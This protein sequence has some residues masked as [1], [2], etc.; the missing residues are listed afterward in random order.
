MGQ[1]YGLTYENRS[2]LGA[3]PEISQ[4][5]CYTSEE[6]ESRN[7]RY[8]QLKCSESNSGDLCLD[9]IPNFHCKSLPTRSRKTNAEQSIVGKRGSMY[10]SSSEISRIRKIQEGRRK[11]DSAFDG[12]AFLSFDIVDSFSQPSTSGAYLHSHQNRRSGPKASVET[13]R[14]V[15]RPSRDFLDLS[16]REL[17]DDNF[18]LDRPRLDC[19]LLKNDGDN[20]FLEISLEKELMKGP[21]RNAAPHLLDIQP[22]KDKE[23]NYQNKTSE[24]NC[25]DRERD[26]AS[27]SKSMPAKVSSF[28][29]SCLSEGVHH[30]MENNTKARSSPF[31]KILDPIMK[32]KSLRSPSIMEKGDSNSITVPVSRKDSM[33]RKSLLSDFSRTEQGSRRP[34]GEVQHVMSA[35]SP[36]HLQA[37]LKLDSRNGIQVFEFCVEGPGESISARSWKTGNDLNSI[38]TFHSGGKRSSAAGRVSKDGGW[39]SPPIIGQVQVSSYLC[40]EVGKDGSVNNSVV[41]EFVSYDIAHAKRALEE[42]TQCTD[43]SQPPLSSVVDKSISGESPQRINLLDQ[44]KIARNNS[45]VST[46]CPW[47]E[48]DLYPH[49]E[50]AATVIKIPFNKDKSKEMKNGSCPCTV[51]VVTPSG[52]HGLPSDNEACPSPLLDRWRY[53]GGC[54]CGGWDM[55]CPIVILGNAYDNDWAESITINAKHPMELF[56]QGSKEELPALSMKANGKG[57]F[58]VDFHGRLSALQAFSVCI[59]LLH[60][61]EALMAISLE[62]G[63]HKLH[64]SSLKMLLEEDVRHLIE[65]V[66]AKERKKPKK[67][68]EKA[69]PTVLLDPPFSPIGRV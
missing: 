53:G 6:S 14:K 41:T 25:D 51:K 30:V 58:L 12:D 52:L 3:D 63:K 55:A 48:E 8:H 17:P 16:F 2:R 38:Y 15:H 10:Q 46:F 57:Q 50:I 32:S 9:R 18:K 64:S 54:D 39:C 35:L 5:S 49:L 4:S 26:S 62:K 66:T 61:S 37:V 29:G 43:T 67:R 20:G 11:I 19:A 44:Q 65:A 68:R 27:S 31:K 69:P 33:S 28:N 47:S 34:N 42:K 21:C 22:A 45:D 24:N 59:S 56:V 60:C 23:T 40:S 7:R 1:D 13:A 36:A